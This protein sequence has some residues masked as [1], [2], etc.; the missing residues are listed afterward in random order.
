[1]SK[2]KL[3][4]SQY[5]EAIHVVG[6][7]ADW[8]MDWYK[9]T[10]IILGDDVCNIWVNIYEEDNFII[11]LNDN[12]ELIRISNIDELKKLGKC[13]VIENTSFDYISEYQTYEV[14]EEDIKRCFGSR[15][16]FDNNINCYILNEK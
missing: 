2:V 7:P 11:E 9:H 6:D 5:K 13:L 8:E 16:I 1:M 4:V 12:P 10:V 3:R 15:A 14:F